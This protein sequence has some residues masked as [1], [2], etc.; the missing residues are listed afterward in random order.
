MNSGALVAKL[1]EMA[2]ETRVRVLYE[3]L[4]WDERDDFAKQIMDPAIRPIRQDMAVCG[5]AYTVADANMSFEMLEDVSKAGCV[6][7]I[8]TS[9]CQGTFVGDFMRELAT[10]D[11]VTGIVT[12]G[13][14]THAAALIKKDLAILAKGSR[15]PYA[16]YSLKGTVQV[17]ITCGGVVVN[18]G[19]I[20]VGNLDGVI[21]LPPDRA[22]DLAEKAQWFGKVVGG[23]IRKYMDKG[24]R[25]VDA[26]GVR[27]YWAH[28]AAGSKNE[29]EFYR[30]WVEKYGET[31]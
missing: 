18:P 11:G 5:P 19:D 17:P 21:V 9:G 8:Q 1:N 20:V 25:Y 28:K 13:Y 10:R 31:E 6:M 2:P 4:P 29:D 15:I 30:E 22:A 14:V 24:I 27:E 23:L 7:V 16:G 12:D 3:V 26:P